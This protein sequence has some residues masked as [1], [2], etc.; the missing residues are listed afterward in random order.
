[1]TSDPSLGPSARFEEDPSLR[2]TDDPRLRFTAEQIG[3]ML[4]GQEAGGKDRRCLPQTPHPHSHLPPD[5]GEP[6]PP[7]GH[8]SRI[9][10]V[11]ESIDA[12][13]AGS[14]HADD[15]QHLTRK[16]PAADEG[17]CRP[18][19]TERVLSCLRPHRLEDGRTVLRRLWRRSVNPTEKCAATVRAL[20]M[21]NRRK[22]SR[23]EFGYEPPQAPSASR[24][25]GGPAGHQAH[26]RAPRGT[27]DDRPGQWARAP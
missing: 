11:R 3:G 4:K 6:M 19:T 18:G 23:K 17:R 24:F 16:S 9:A 21:C 1:M 25:A 8:T 12:R 2:A 13:S 20:P 5:Q 15:G 26:W 27:R 10:G 7:G 22:G 14:G